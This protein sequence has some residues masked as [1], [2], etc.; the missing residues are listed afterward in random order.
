MQS[1]QQGGGQ[2]PGQPS[3]RILEEFPIFLPNVTI[4]EGPRVMY[5]LSADL[6]LADYANHKMPSDL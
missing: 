3:Q 4:R 2:S 1:I 6:T 5:H